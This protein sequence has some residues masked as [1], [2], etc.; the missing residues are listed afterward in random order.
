MSEN[1]SIYIFKDA[2]P[3]NECFCDM[4]NVIDL[5]S[6]ISTFLSYFFP[7]TRPLTRHLQ[8][9]A[10]CKA[11][12]R[13]G[14]APPSA[15]SCKSPSNPRGQ[16]RGSV[17]LP[18][19]SRAPG[20]AEL[21][22]CWASRRTDAFFPAAEGKLNGKLGAASSSP[23]AELRGTGLVH[24]DSWGKRG[25]AAKSV[26]FTAEGAL[27]LVGWMQPSAVSWR[28]HTASFYVALTLIR[29][30]YRYGRIRLVVAW[31]GVAWHARCCCT[32]RCASWHALLPL[33][34]CRRT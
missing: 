20:D 7:K 1:V 11:A 25:G 21:S 27:L 24:F 9:D 31:R 26:L 10:A 29:E 4:L 33:E 19:R 18:P 28:D 8:G 14:L 16:D 2:T 13:A 5:K 3:E 23:G 34:K 17:S 6:L 32:I 22:R 12:A 15:D 30:R